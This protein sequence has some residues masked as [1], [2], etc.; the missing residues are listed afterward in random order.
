[1]S[2][3][4]KTYAITFNKGLDKA[5]LPFQADPSRALDEINY[6]YRD[7]KVQKRHGYTELI[8]VAKT[9]YTIV[10]FDGTKTGKI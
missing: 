9:Y 8:N 4:R 6:V 5:S 2:E 3:T 10:K 7:G 1:M